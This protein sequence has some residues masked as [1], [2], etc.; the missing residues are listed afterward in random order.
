[1]R[2]TII[3]DDKTVYVDGEAR[4]VA[5]TGIDPRVHAVQWYGDVGEVELK[6]PRENVGIT[7]LSPYQVFIDRWTAVGPPPVPPPPLTDKQ[8]VEQQLANNLTMK[9]LVEELAARFG[10]TPTAFADSIKGRVS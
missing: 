6:A 2:V 8:L 1:M 3:P 9:T 7:D 10:V 5:M 4:E